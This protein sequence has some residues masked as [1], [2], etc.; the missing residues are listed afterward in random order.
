M[1]NGLFYPEA[2][3]IFKA[4]QNGDLAEVQS[5]KRLQHSRDQRGRTPL[6]YSI[7]LKK[8]EISKYLINLPQSPINT[9]DEDG[10]TPLMIAAKS[11][12]TLLARLLVEKGAFVGAKDKSNRS[13]LEYA[14][15]S[16]DKAF[17]AFMEKQCAQLELPSSDQVSKLVNAVKLGEIDHVKKFYACFKDF[18]FSTKSNRH[19]S[20]EAVRM[21]QKETL[22]LL[23]Q[24]GADSSVQDRFGRSPVHLACLKNTE[25]SLLKVLIQYGAELEIK[26]RDGNRPIHS[27]S[28]NGRHEL[29]EMLI[30]AGVDIDVINNKNEAP[31][32]Y[33]INN[34]EVTRKLLLAGSNPNILDDEGSTPLMKAA[35]VLNYAVY[36]ELRESG[37][38]D[39]NI[40]N[41]NGLTATEI[42]IQES[43]ID[44]VDIAANLDESIENTKFFQFNNDPFVPNQLSELDE[45]T[46]IDSSV[47]ASDLLNTDADQLIL[48][49]FKEYLLE[50][51][52]S[53]LDEINLAKNDGGD[54]SDDP[55]LKK[56]INKVIAVRT[57]LKELQQRYV[58]AEATLTNA[59][60]EFNLVI[61]KADLAKTRAR[62]K[63]KAAKSS[64]SKVAIAAANLNSLLHKL[65]DYSNRFSII[66]AD[67][68][69]LK[70][71]SESPGGVL[72]K[73]ADAKEYFRQ[74]EKEKQ[75][76]VE[77]A[78]TTIKE[79]QNL[80]K[81]LKMDLNRSLKDQETKVSARKS[82][83]NFWSLR[84][85]ENEKAVT[86]AQNRLKEHLANNKLPSHHKNYEVHDPANCV[87]KK[88]LDAQTEALRATKQKRDRF[89]KDW[90]AAQEDLKKMRS[91]L[92]SI[93][94]ERRALKQQVA[95]LTALKF[96]TEKEISDLQERR[97]LKL[98]E[99]KFPELEYRRELLDKRAEL[100]KECIAQYGGNPNK[101][102]S[103]VNK[104]KNSLSKPPTRSLLGPIHLGGYSELLM[105]S[106]ENSGAHD[107]GPIMDRADRLRSEWDRYF[108]RY[109][110]AI[111]AVNHWRR[112][113]E[114]ADELALKLQ[115]Y[116]KKAKRLDLAQ[117]SLKEE[118]SYAEAISRSLSDKSLEQNT[119]GQDLLSLKQILRSILDL[120]YKLV[121]SSFDAEQNSELF[122][123]VEDI[124]REGQQI[125]SFEMDLFPTILRNKTPFYS[126]KLA[127]LKSVQGSQEFKFL[128]PTNEILKT[129]QE[130]KASQ[131]ASLVAYWTSLF[132]FSDLSSVSEL[133]QVV[134][135][136]LLKKIV[137]KAL[138]KKSRFYQVEFQSGKRTYQIQL[139]RRRYWIDF[140]GRL[141]PAVDVKTPGLF[142][143]TFISD[144]NSEHGKA[145]REIYAQLKVHSAELS[146][147]DL[148]N[149]KQGQ[150][151]AIDALI[152]TL[153]R[154]KM[155]YD[156]LSGAEGVKKLA[157]LIM[158]GLVPKVYLGTQILSSVIGYDA[159]GSVISKEKR[160]FALTK[161]ILKKRFK[162][163]EKLKLE[164]LLE[165]ELAWSFIE[166][167]ALN[168]E[169]VIRNIKDPR[170]VF[171]SN[172]PHKYVL[173]AQELS[174]ELSYA[175]KVD[176]G[177][178]LN[179][180]HPFFDPWSE[181]DEVF[182]LYTQREK[183]F[184]AVFGFGK[185]D[186]F[187]LDFDPRN[188]TVADRKKCVPNPDGK[189]EKI[190]KVRVPVGTTLLYGLSRDSNCT[191]YRLIDELPD[192]LWSTLND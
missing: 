60:L 21:S 84:V 191:I 172:L 131:K 110:V 86:R 153:D 127:G 102:I 26:D 9:A 14:K 178:E 156:A 174:R 188:L 169:L 190:M 173:E 145:L 15:R 138:L 108:D 129:I 63:S 168:T 23:L 106:K 113:K 146:L 143:Y 158:K 93:E 74:Q 95:D 132:K 122:G 183:T 16:K 71:D 97:E 112:L 189:E 13:V 154:N 62:S 100:R 151:I 2:S 159:Y 73:I 22:E 107:L 37:Q 76:V 47:L 165:K 148:A 88:Q 90:L 1:L 7:S 179:K 82:E 120:E 66:N 164:G 152:R 149:Y 140:D 177:K 3:S 114:K 78:Q 8:T 89:K 121:V 34:M 36:R 144:P 61:S 128:D 35:K 160:V 96:K 55:E 133:Y 104:I 135:E 123:I 186:V 27:A 28:K 91:D 57:K 6:L 147:G 5:L 162:I 105:Y 4:I 180:N 170:L 166:S 10:R 94:V 184:F 33:S 119:D 192:S 69:Q 163:D 130:V 11:S 79:K 41:P 109:Q 81:K 58:K 54:V 175:T 141:L 111:S 44:S 48:E 72:E 12:K 43:D 50:L 139:G 103:S 45:P 116:E 142:N 52:N 67:L 56:A 157:N 167:L 25:S 53:A 83:A 85:Q 101:I 38:V 59:K 51:K 92:A 187:L 31:L 18:N 137:S 124:K 182:Q 98:H 134:P 49:V 150:L 42:F 17:I 161:I 39:G 126:I 155:Y 68:E 87:P 29:V 136:A 30:Q 115:S 77:K 75:V 125:E 40:E 20:I 171:K 65:S 46:N 117:R 70:A 19:P 99:L 176:S 80:Y 24:G 185:K 32:H 118:V 64:Y 181:D